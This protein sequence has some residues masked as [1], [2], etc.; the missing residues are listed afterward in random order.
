MATIRRITVAEEK[1]KFNTEWKDKYLFTSV[2]TKT[3]CLIYQNSIAQT[4]GILKQN[5]GEKYGKYNI[6]EKR[7][8]AEKLTKNLQGQQKVFIRSPDDDIANT[9]VSFEIAKILSKH[10]KPF[11]DGLIVKDC[12]QKFA[13][14]KCSQILKS[15]SDVSLSR[16]TIA[17]RVED[18]GSDIVYQLK[19]KLSGIECYSLALYENGA[20][21]MIGCHNGLFAKV[22]ELKPDIIA[23]HCIL[24]KEN[25]SAKL[26]NMDHVNSVVVKTVNYTPSRGLNQRELQEFLV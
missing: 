23:V 11:S 12:L 14:V 5:H 15:V 10:Q 3:I 19:L 18:M 9:I 4:K 24:Q 8:L 1:R 2:N 7:K 22:R 6:E 26:I 16:R 20:P 17:K 25:L 13:E 21:S